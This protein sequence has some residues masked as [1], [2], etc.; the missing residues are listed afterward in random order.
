MVTWKLSYDVV[1]KRPHPIVR[2]YFNSIEFVPQLFALQ[3]F[4]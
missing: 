3:V 1:N 4:K 2:F